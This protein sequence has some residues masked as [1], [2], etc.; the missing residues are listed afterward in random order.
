MVIEEDD[1]DF[2]YGFNCAQWTV[3][4]HVWWLGVKS[5]GLYLSCCC[6]NHFMFLCCQLFLFS[7][8]ADSSQEAV[9]A[10]VS[11]A[12]LVL[13]CRSWLFHRWFE[14]GKTA[15]MYTWQWQWP[16]FWGLLKRIRCLTSLPIVH[17]PLRMEDGFYFGTLLQTIIN[18]DDKLRGYYV[19]CESAADCL[20]RAPRIHCTGCF[21][22]APL[23]SRVG[24]SQSGAQSVAWKSLCFSVIF[25]WQLIA[26]FDSLFCWN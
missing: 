8:H 15:C 19:S 23:N 2:A 22:S 21:V 5:T 26:E 1:D 3:Y 4:L 10:C 13:L 18:D 25:R 20:V 7:F 17:K 9:L 24:L 11:V 14:L 16:V 12:L 6:L